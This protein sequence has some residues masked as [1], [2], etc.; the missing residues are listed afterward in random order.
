[1]PDEDAVKLAHGAG[2][3]AASEVESTDVVLEPP[4]PALAVY[5][6][7]VRWLLRSSLE[8][9]SSISKDV[10]FS[11][12]DMSDSGDDNSDDGAS[13]T[14]GEHNVA[15][16]EPFAS[17]RDAKLARAEV[18]G[19]LEAV[20]DAL[21]IAHREF[22]SIDDKR[23]EVEDERDES[24]ERIALLE[25]RIV[26]HLQ[27]R[28]LAIAEK[29]TTEK[30]IEEAEL[31]KA[32]NPQRQSSSSLLGFL[33]RSG[34]SASF[35][36]KDVERL[37]RDFADTKVAAALAKSELDTHYYRLRQLERKCAGVKFEIA[38][39]SALEDDLRASL[40]HLARERK[41][42]LEKLHQ[43]SVFSAEAS[44]LMR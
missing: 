42:S 32:Q 22:S 5:D 14:V 9:L 39:A 24:R 13:N 20:I 43:I 18:E 41:H 35:S 11:L 31:F 17:L 21:S 36:E 6:P 8:E 38:Q 27:D 33:R 7:F 40:E 34:S 25:A 29:Y 28:D 15:A 16:R 30:Q 4:S 2:D 10:P 19:E 26:K 12:A 3:A 1:M 37:Q 44:V 23:L